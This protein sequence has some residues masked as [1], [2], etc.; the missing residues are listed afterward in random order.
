MMIRPPWNRRLLLLSIAVASAGVGCSRSIIPDGTV[1][2][3]R[4]FAYLEC[5]DC[6]RGQRAVVIRMGDS[7]VPSLRVALER[8]PDSQ[9]VQ[10]LDS[11]LRRRLTLLRP[12]IAERQV[13]AYRASYTRRAADALGDIGGGLAISALCAGRGN[14]PPGS[15]DRKT[16]DSALVRSSGTCP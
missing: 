15:V 16:I 2:D 11:T 4:V 5:I 14:T 8:G 10:I 13:R 6:L 9:R 1:I 7:A 3:T 12:G